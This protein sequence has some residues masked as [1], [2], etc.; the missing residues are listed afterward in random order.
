MY[1]Y[2]YMYV[3]T[4]ILHS[5][6]IFSPSPFPFSHPSPPPQ[7]S[8]FPLSLPPPFQIVPP[9]AGV[10]GSSST[11]SVAVEVSGNAASALAPLA[12]SVAPATQLPHQPVS[13]QQPRPHAI[14][15]CQ[16]KTEHE[17]HVL[18][19]SLAVHIM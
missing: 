1:M 5:L 11:G 6:L 9:T 15:E 16:E 7:P 17:H 4:Q 13:T 18:Y 10:G 12:S 19:D 8:P 3:Q 2:M 14:S